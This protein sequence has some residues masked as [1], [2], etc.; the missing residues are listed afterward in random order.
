M[1]NV[2]VIPVDVG[3]CQS[4]AVCKYDIAFIIFCAL[5]TGTTPTHTV[6]I[7]CWGTFHLLSG[8]GGVSWYPVWLKW[9]VLL[10]PVIRGRG[11]R[12]RLLS[13][14]EWVSPCLLACS[15]S[16]LSTWATRESRPAV[17]VVF[18]TQQET[19]PKLSLRV[20]W[21][22]MFSLVPRPFFATREKLVWWMAY[23]IFVPCGCKNC[24]VTLVG[25]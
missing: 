21:A 6:Y 20:T 13:R 17:N 11:R 3:T 9:R 18:L 4:S 1:H 2:G 16:S 7:H 12:W 10:L 14:Y 24:D 25:M 8:D 23:S 5:T 22:C 15:H 19:S